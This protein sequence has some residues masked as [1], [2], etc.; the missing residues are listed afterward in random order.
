MTTNALTPLAR[1][2]YAW[3]QEPSDIGRANA[4]VVVDED[5]LTV[6]DTLMVPSQYE[7]FA[8]AVAELGRPV[9]RVV[10]TSGGIEFAGGT[11]KFPL[12]AVFGTR[13][14]STHLDQ[15]PNVEGYRTFLPEFAD[16]F[17][18]VATR[19]VSHVVDAAAALSP[20]VEVIPVP[21]QTPG[22]LV[23][24]VLAANVLFA[25]ATCS[26]GVTPLAFQSNFDAWT[27]A[28]GPVS[29]MAETIVPG[30]GPLGGSAQV[31]ELRG[32]LRACVDAGGDPDQ[33]SAGPW[34]GWAARHLDEIN[35]ERAH[36]Q[37]QG[38]HQVP[39]SMLRA[40]GST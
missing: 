20:A 14:T 33:I 18:H 30:H 4:G 1:G 7:P 11:S 28:L 29:E 2:V 32:Y 12:A 16:E 3:I 24:R 26:F 39:P 35:V 27:G 10:L 13:L 15:E 34:D 36:L 40:I 22:N 19:P 37:A 21:G 23:V 38:E 8:A 31:D 9:R 6:V 5:G 25:G 17:E